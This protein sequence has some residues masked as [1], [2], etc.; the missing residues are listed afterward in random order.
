[1]LGAEFSDYRRYASGDDLRRIDWNIYGRLRELL[2]EVGPREERL[3]VEILI[4]TS[5]SM[6]VGTPGKLDHARRLAAGLGA[7]GLFQSDAVRPWALHDGEATPGATLSSPRLL[8][9][10]AGEIRALPVGQATSL[11]ASLRAFRRA[12]PRSDIAVLICDGLAEPANL[13]AA[14]EELSASAGSAAFVHVTDLAH[15]LPKR[16]PVRLRDAETGQPMRVTVTT[17][18]RTAY[19]DNYE[20]FARAVANACADAG[21]GYVRASTGASAIDQLV[22]FSFIGGSSGR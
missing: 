9:V 11:A 4:D 18:L 2:V 17:A 21:V 22:E 5:R 6:R 15:A 7:V 19:A 16:G 12:V 8:A 13:S 3:T 14:L 20:R 1:M 10:L